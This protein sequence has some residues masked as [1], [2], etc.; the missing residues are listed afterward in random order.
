[1]A[2]TAF[3]LLTP[4]N[5]SGVLGLARATLDG[6]TL[7]VDVAASN[8][9]PGQVHP[10]HLH[11]F[12]DDRPERLAVA[13]D[14]AD[15]DGRVETAEGES[16][17]Y[18]PVIAGLTASGNAGFGL[19]VSPDFPVAGPDGTLRFSQTYA[20]NPSDAD[21]ARILERLDARF[22]GRVLEFHG[23][24]LPPGAGAGTPGEANGTGG[25]QAALPVA[26]GPLLGVEGE[27]AALATALL[28]DAFS[29]SAAF[30]GRAQ[31]TLSLLAPYTLNQAGTGPLAPEPPGAAVSPTDTYAA[32]LAP[33]NG[34]GALGAALVTLNRAETSVTVDLLMTGLEP[35]QEHASHTHGFANDAPSLLPNY[36]LDVDNDGFVEDQ[37]GEE[38]VGPVILGLTV[39]GSISDAAL[40][41]A[42]PVADA[43]G[44]LYLRQTYD[45]DISDPVQKTLFGELEDRLGGREVQVHGLTVP[46]TEGEG[47]TYEVNGEA[48][49]KPGL[50][51][52]N[53]IL[54]PVADADAARELVA[55]SRSLDKAVAN[56]HAPIDLE[57][58]G[59]RA[60][61]DY[62]GQEQFVL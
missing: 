53:G 61:A 3:A 16:Q 18:G 9:T 20:L 11:G 33:S 50:P 52:A 59:G 30:L 10:F 44:N 45:F 58:V 19:E 54:L 13:A 62:L 47:T 2:E 40:T 24:D 12:L 21:D 31:A 35:G 1:M 41:A 29:S 60:L 37:E 28:G 55:V 7:K 5:N 15:G 56:E 23:L 43:A 38:V 22:E 4:A 8:L 17:A 32:L 46:A 49:Y 48:G 14:D 34:S 25:Y 51:V 27:I 42:F 36:R 39:D 6:T 57:E 26:Q